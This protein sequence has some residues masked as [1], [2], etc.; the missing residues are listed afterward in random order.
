MRA[1]GKLLHLHPLTLED[2]LQREQREK[3]EVF[4]GLGYYFVVFRAVEPYHHASP[5]DDEGHHRSGGSD[6]VV[7]VTVYLVVFREG[8]CSFHFEDISEHTD[9]VRN[10]ILQ[11]EKTIPWTPDWI[12]HG[13]LDSIVDG[14]FPIIQNIEKEV[15]ELDGLVSGIENMDLS[16]LNLP[17][18]IQI[19][20]PPDTKPTLSPHSNS[21]VRA[22]ADEGDE[23][24]KHGLRTHGS[25]RWDF[26]SAIR[27]CIPGVRSAR[28]QAAPKFEDEKAHFADFSKSRTLTVSHPVLERLGNIFLPNALLP[29]SKLSTRS[30]RSSRSSI[31]SNSSV[32]PKPS[33]RYNLLR[34]IAACRRL[35]TSLTRILTPKN[36]VVAQ[37]RKRIL[38]DGS[39]VGN[40]NGNGGGN[41][42]LV[43]PGGSGLELDIYWGDVQDH[44]MTMHHSLVHYERILSHSHPAYLSHLRW[45][46][47]NGKG[48]IDRA[49]LTLTSVSITCFSIQLCVG[50]MSMNVHIP[51]N[52]RPQDVP[53][54]E[55]L[56]PGH[57]Y[58]F[59]GLLAFVTL[60]VIGV[61]NLIRYWWRKAKRKYRKHADI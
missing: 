16:D 51:H 32:R 35:V 36:E 23:D 2:I 20:R 1:L 49:I 7:A 42:M 14:F 26:A 53:D 57:F 3:L 10:R 40:A 33:A 4:P 48:G 59:G 8:I 13:L 54:G 22:T 31:T 38:S 11:L 47:S 60:V 24:E 12:A 55:D 27:S 6:P 45:S 17:A 61:V 52:R 43:R 9:R 29:K 30:S 46:L 5:G 56:P 18:T 39:L 41:S 15:D 28:E 25:S 58:T 37:I 44:I 21:T 50:V 19:Q 34:R